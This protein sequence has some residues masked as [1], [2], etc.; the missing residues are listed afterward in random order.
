MKENPSI[1]E[2]PIYKLFGALTRFGLTLELSAVALTE[3]LYWGA[4]LLVKLFV[5]ASFNIFGSYNYMV[6]ALRDQ[7]IIIIVLPLVMRYTLKIEDFYNKVLKEIHAS[8]NVV[9]A[10]SKG[11]RRKLHHRGWNLLL[12]IILVTIYGALNVKYMLTGT[13]SIDFAI[14]RFIVFYALLGI[15]CFIYQQ[16]VLVN[17]SYNVFSL[18]R[19]K[20]ETYFTRVKEFQEIVLLGS[21]LTL[22][23][24]FTLLLTPLILGFYLTSLIW[25]VSFHG[26]ISTVSLYLFL[27][28]MRG[29]HESRKINVGFPLLLPPIGLSEN[30][31]LRGQVISNKYGSKESVVILPD[32][33]MGNYLVLLLG[34]FFTIFLLMFVRYVW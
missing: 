1:T 23:L 34:F 30:K 24:S 3:I 8:Q 11:F 28:A 12:G 18:Y 21:F 22:L 10:L 4:Y 15:S 32:I 6:F 13:R 5:N 20:Q 9:E 31:N 26:F 33:N 27:K 16:I 14:F 17:F 29:L 7:V 19:F 2:N 25:Y